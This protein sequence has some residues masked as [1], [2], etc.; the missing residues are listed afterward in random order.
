MMGL[1]KR[2]KREKITSNLFSF[3]PK[4]MNYV[5]LKHC[6]SSKANLPFSLMGYVA[7]SGLENL[8]KKFS[9]RASDRAKP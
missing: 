3:G 5:N 8:V 2:Q 7:D 6:R 4:T 9:I 1:K